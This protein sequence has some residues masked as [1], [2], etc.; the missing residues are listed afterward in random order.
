VLIIALPRPFDALLVASVAWCAAM[1]I[2]T[3]VVLANAIRTRSR[4]H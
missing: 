1:T 4:P 2:I 3:G